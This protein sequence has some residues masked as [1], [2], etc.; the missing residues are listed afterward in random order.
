M[1]VFG[2]I[3]CIWAKLVQVGHK[4][5]AQIE[6][7][8]PKYNQFARLYSGKLVIFGQKWMFSGKLVLFEQNWLYSGKFCCIWAKCVVFGQTGCIWAKLVVFG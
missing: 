5:Y 2:Q 3:C 6:L 8:S 4:L 7:I 1:V